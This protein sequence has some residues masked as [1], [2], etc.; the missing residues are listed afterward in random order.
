MHKREIS[1][2]NLSRFLSNFDFE[3]YPLVF[4]Y[5]KIKII[6]IKMV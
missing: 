6:T 1:Q 5:I 2:E 3:I 4:I